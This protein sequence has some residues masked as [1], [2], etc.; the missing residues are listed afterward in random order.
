M[1]R[2]LQ[3]IGRPLKNIG[4]ASEW[5]ACS[6]NPSR[7]WSRHS[8]VCCAWFCTAAIDESLRPS[9]HLIPQ[10]MSREPYRGSIPAG[11]QLA[12]SSEVSLLSN[13]FH[14]SLR[15]NHKSAA[16]TIKS[17]Q[18][19]VT[20]GPLLSRLRSFLHLFS[21]DSRQS[22]PAWSYDSAQI[23]GAAIWHPFCQGL[24]SEKQNHAIFPKSAEMV[25]FLSSKTVDCIHH[26][27]CVESE[28]MNIICCTDL[29]FL[30]GSCCATHVA[31]QTPGSQ[32]SELKSVIKILQPGVRPEATS[33]WSRV[34]QQFTSN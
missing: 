18:L 33:L 2:L 30:C 9:L 23:F 27:P 31:W 5:S 12:G 8:A 1:S 15:W 7:L 19:L 17:R 34:G 25:P 10:S 11:Q 29:W 32:K 24:H 4:T 28:L 22:I 3:K 26:C 6:I 13:R 21:P 16:Q 20:R 14:V